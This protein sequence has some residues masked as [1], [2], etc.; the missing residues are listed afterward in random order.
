[1]DSTVWECSLLFASV[2]PPL[3]WNV[4]GSCLH[5]QIIAVVIRQENVASLL[6]D[7]SKRLQLL[8]LWWW[9]VS[10]FWPHLWHRGPLVA[11]SCIAPHGVHQRVGGERVVG[12]PC[13]HI[14]LE[15]LNDRPVGPED[16]KCPQTQMRSQRQGDTT[17]TSFQ[18]RFTANL[19][20]SSWLWTSRHKTD[21]LLK[22]MILKMFEP[23]E[24][25]NIYSGSHNQTLCLSP[26][27]F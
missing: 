5:Q 24:T 16:H 13:A 3:Y 23:S 19:R 22:G 6:K 17:Q 14:L 27:G 8:V 7:D 15:A 9:S 12:G 10:V 21:T 18:L 26:D 1:M 4:R 2:S 25:C 20:H 11:D